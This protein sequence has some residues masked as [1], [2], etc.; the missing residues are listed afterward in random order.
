MAFFKQAL[1][2]CGIAGRA[3][4]GN[5]ASIKLRSFWSRAACSGVSLSFR[6]T[7]FQ[8]FLAMLFPPS[9]FALRNLVGG[10]HPH[11]VRGNLFINDDNKT[12][13]GRISPG[14]GEACRFA[15]PFIS[16][17]FEHM[18]H[19]LHSKVVLGNMFY[20]AVGVVLVIPE[21]A[22]HIH[23]GVLWCIIVKWLPVVK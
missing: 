18:L 17:I 22:P 11:G 5:S 23:H 14:C 4:G 6:K 2:E 7:R 1:S 3:K 10:G 19:V 15:D 21:K 8:T 12:A 16:R 13:I 20:V 9:A